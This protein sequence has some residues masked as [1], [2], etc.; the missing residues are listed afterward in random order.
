MAR[1]AGHRLNRHAWDDITRLAGLSITQVADRAEIPRPTIS[2]LVRGSQRAS[3]PAAHKLA[4]AVGVHPAT[5][6]PSLLGPLERPEAVT[7]AAA[8]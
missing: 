6:F 1:P 7:T 8:S 5:L 2:G 4:D 3:T